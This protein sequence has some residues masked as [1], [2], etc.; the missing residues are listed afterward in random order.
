MVDAGVTGINL[1]F[2]TFD[3][4]Q[5]E[6]MTRR[7]GFSAVIRSI[8]HILALKRSGA[9]NN[10]KLKINVVVMRGTNGL[11]Y[12]EISTSRPADSWPKINHIE[13]GL[14]PVSNTTVK[15]LCTR[16]TGYRSKMLQ[17]TDIHRSNMS[18]YLGG[19]SPSDNKNWTP[20][21][22]AVRATI[23]F[24]IATGRLETSQPHEDTS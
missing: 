10:L 6:Q 23:P 2:D 4:A 16:W 1:S 24:A 21:M 13:I 9:A 18:F 8:G 19:K 14:K 15:H 20:N 5:F 22:A 7:K 12:Q 3:P 17:C 11:G